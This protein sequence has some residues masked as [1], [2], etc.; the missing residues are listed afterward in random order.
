MFSWSLS[1]FLIL[2]Y[3][4]TV[5][6]ASDHSVQIIHLLTRYFERSGSD[7]RRGE[8][9]YR[10]HWSPYN[11]QSPYKWSSVFGILRLWFPRCLPNCKSYS[12]CPTNFWQ[13]S[14]CF[15][16]LKWDVKPA[17]G[18]FT[19]TNFKNH[20]NA[21]VSS[22]TMVNVIYNWVQSHPI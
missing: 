1:H 16:S 11:Q 17:A 18:G 14:D 9:F 7:I 21:F 13:C 2:V 12:E 4:S 19:I 5:A 15:T 20:Y 8:I 10:K 3:A 22:A 6:T